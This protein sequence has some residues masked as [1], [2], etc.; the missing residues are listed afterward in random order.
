MGKQFWNDVEALSREEIRALQL[1][2]L[3]EQ[4]QYLSENSP[5]Y[6]SIFQKYKIMPEAFRSLA[7]LKRVPFLD[8]HIAGES[9]EHCPPF[10][11]F[12]C[13]PER[14][15]VKYFR[16]S[17]T[18]L[19]PRNM[20]YTWDDWMNCSVEVMTRMKYAIGVRAEDRAFIAFPYSTF[21]SLW[22]AHYAC[23]KIG[24]MVI[25]G[26]GLSTRERLHLMRDMKVTV[27]CST[28]TYAYRLA[29]V[30]EEEGIDIR[31]IPLRIIHTGGEPMAAVPGSRRRLEELWQAKVY[32]DYG[33]SEALAPVGGECVA[34]D[35]LHVAEDILITE[36]LN[37]GGEQVA[38]GETGELVTSNILARGMPVLRFRTSDLV[39]YTDE[40][41]SCGRNTTRLKVLG[42]SDDMIIIKGTNVFPSTV[43]EIVKRCPELSNE[44]MIVLDEIDGVYELIIQVEPCVK[45][46]CTL[47][48][49]EAI[50]GKI[51]EMMRDT[52][53]LRPVVQ[54]M[55]PGSLPRFE[56]KAK[57]VVD[58]RAKTR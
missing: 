39:T 23:E 43:E 37:E 41:C 20:A 24:C 15:I 14:D 55:A 54:V 38:P 5:F 4:V 52:L 50:R 10:G 48:Q 7:D 30:A 46:R 25:P 11:E 34:Q 9:Q 32:D 17:G 51:V 31:S 16:T 21:V 26:G 2:R 3:R 27:L 53:R 33:H 58:K 45:E 8:K 13:V 36:V 6:Q 42:R 18:T 1:N 44:F 12:L 29:S 49:E 57:R 22:N 40:P 47:D 56:T 19:R 35:G 28:P